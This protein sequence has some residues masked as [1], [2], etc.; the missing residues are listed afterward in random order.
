MSDLFREEAIEHRRNRLYGDVIISASPFSN[1]SVVVI[2]AIG[3]A[4]IGWAIMTEYSRTETVAGIIT[5]TK[6]TTKVFAQRFGTLKDLRVKEGQ[7]VRSG[8]VLAVVSVDVP[9]KDGRFLGTSDLAEIGMQRELVEREV[10][11][12][13][14]AFG[15]EKKRLASLIRQAS[16]EGQ[17]LEAQ[18]ATQRVILESAK[19]VF[20]L[21][22]TVVADGI[23]SR[24]DYETRHREVL[25][26]QQ[27]VHQL[28]QERIKVAGQR[29]QYEAQLLKADTDYLKQ[30]SE[31]SLKLSSLEQQR[32]RAQ[33][34]VDYQILAPMDGRVSS[35]QVSNGRV[36][37]AKLPMMVIVPTDLEFQ[38]EVYAPSRSV[39][40]VR[41]GQPVRI[42]FDAFPYQRFGSF[43]GTI[44]TISH[45]ISGPGDLDVPIKLEEPVYRVLVML[46]KQDVHAN[47]AFF[48]LQSG[49]T[50]KANIVLEKRS[51]SDWLLAPLNAVR[52]RSS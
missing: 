10:L 15:D 13:E 40:F 35:L 22:G 50:L 24:N 43:G 25:Q 48:P 31:V 14:R 1:I 36:I 18:T 51:F 45:S 34:E 11:N 47:G 32:N 9:S 8:D 17:S 3:S 2:A 6:P 19:A 44:K 49:M 20:D 42:M 30:K 28:E 12:M 29:A 7:D 5:T 27:R 52:S 23:V 38:A 37:D 33:G 21:F 46:T 39:G 4:L 41:E 16:L 26:A